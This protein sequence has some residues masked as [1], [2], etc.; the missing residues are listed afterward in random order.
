LRNAE[1]TE[2]RGRG[3][4]SHTVWTHPKYKGIVTL[5]GQDGADADRYQE[6]QVCK[7]IKESKS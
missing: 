3:K 1:F 2:V 7:A 4:A 6:Q 5:S